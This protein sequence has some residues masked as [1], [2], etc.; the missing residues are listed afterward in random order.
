[1]V[2]GRLGGYAVG[3]WGAELVSE[4]EARAAIQRGEKI[5]IDDGGSLSTLTDV[6]LEKEP[7]HKPAWYPVVLAYR[8]AGMF[9]N[10]LRESDEPA[11]D[12]MMNAI[13]DDRP[14]AEAVTIGYHDNVRSLWEKFIKSS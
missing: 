13:L 6:R 14:F 4:D 11:F 12:R 7:A 8:E 2:Q 9:V 1:L 10:Y 3:R 5:V